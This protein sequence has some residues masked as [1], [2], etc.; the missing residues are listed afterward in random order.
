MGLTVESFMNLSPPQASEIGLFSENNKVDWSFFY[1]VIYFYLFHAESFILCKCKNHNKI[2]KFLC[3]FWELVCMDW[4]EKK[5]RE[6]MIKWWR[7]QEK[8]FMWEQKRQS[9]GQSIWESLNWKPG[10]YEKDKRLLIIFLNFQVFLLIF[11]II[12]FTGCSRKHLSYIFNSCDRLY[13]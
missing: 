7:S 5:E 4:M 2:I 9:N 10:W 3:W 8:W 13:F 12:L 6:M 1:L 11:I